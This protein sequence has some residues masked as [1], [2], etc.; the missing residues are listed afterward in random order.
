MFLQIQPC[1]E[2]RMNE[3]Q[4]RSIIYE[5]MHFHWE[6]ICQ[7]MYLTV[8]NEMFGLNRCTHSMDREIIVLFRIQAVVID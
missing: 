4:V 1:N 6:I 2:L 5:S 7:P 8:Q 3:D